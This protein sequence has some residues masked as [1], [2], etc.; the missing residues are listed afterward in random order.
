M[1]TDINYNILLLRKA[2]DMGTQL[3]ALKINILWSLA[4]WL[5]KEIMVTSFESNLVIFKTVW[6]WYFT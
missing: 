5:N 4:V 3:N 2:L 6:Q 1:H